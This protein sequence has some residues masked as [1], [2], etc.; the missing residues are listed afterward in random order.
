[1]VNACLRG[2]GASR[3]FARTMQALRAL[4]ADDRPDFRPDF[5]HVEGWIFDLDNTLYP[6]GCDLFAQIDARMTAFVAARL[7]LDE[8]A[9]RTLQKAYYRDHG[10][11]LNGLMRVNG[12]DPE[13][14][15][16]FVHAVDLS[17]LTPEPAMRDG[18]AR[19]PG[20]RFIFTNGCRRHA[21][22]VLDALELDDLFE[23]VWDIR[24][25]GFRPK[26]DPDSYRAM[27]DRAGLEARACAMFEDAARN[28]VPA[29]TLGMTTVWLKNGSP[30][31]RQGPEHPRADARHIHHQTEDLA[32]FL[33]GIRTRDL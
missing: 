23:D 21:A 11:T 19:L 13:E 25:I 12:V 10:T 32:A 3:I 1:M 5:R 15:L 18:V 29:H 33:G 2:R 28:L 20:R 8:G 31:S 27:L 16:A 14:F 7:E 30:W 22:R 4:D 26:P 9:A 17:V 24:S 6:A